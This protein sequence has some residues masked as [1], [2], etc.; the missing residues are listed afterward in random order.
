MMMS[1]TVDHMV[2]LT[3]EIVLGHFDIS[4]QTEPIVEF[5][6]EVHMMP[7]RVGYRLVGS[8]GDFDHELVIQLVSP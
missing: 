4:N 7:N 2:D 3:L 1:H 6:F 5:E 8:V